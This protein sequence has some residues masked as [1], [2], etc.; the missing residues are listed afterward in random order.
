MTTILNPCYFNLFMYSILFPLI[1]VFVIYFLVK[2][3]KR[4][5]WPKVF[6]RKITK[7]LGKQF[8][9][10]W[11]AKDDGL[12]DLKIFDSAKRV[13]EKYSIYFSSSLEWTP[14]LKN[15]EGPIDPDQAVILRKEM[16]NYWVMEKSV[17][18]D[19]HVYKFEE[20]PDGV[21]MLFRDGELIG[22]V[23]S[24]IT[25]SN[26]VCFINPPDPKCFFNSTPSWGE[27]FVW[28]DNYIIKSYTEN[29]ATFKINND[30]L[31]LPKSWDGKM[32]AHAFVLD[33]DG[34]VESAVF[35][36][37]ETLNPP[38]PLDNIYWCKYLGNGKLSPPTLIISQAHLESAS[39]NE[40]N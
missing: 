38:I 6:S 8:D 32:K 28:K 18:C 20:K 11:K 34:V 22:E 10:L 13:F 16:D 12:L 26:K 31:E 29:S 7:E 1:L 37:K 3:Y 35:E 17:I 23:K 27:V 25:D 2:E 36:I 14:L 15:D 4:Y 40:V 30:F 9:K 5:R 39:I 19:N 33:K 21:F 24:G